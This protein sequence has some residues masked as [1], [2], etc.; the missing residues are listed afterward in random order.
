[1]SNVPLPL[2]CTLYQIFPL[3]LVILTIVG[4]VAVISAA[5]DE[6]DKASG[7]IP[8]RPHAVHPEVVGDLSQRLWSVPCTKSRWVPRYV[9]GKAKLPLTAGPVF[10]A[11]CPPRDFQ[12]DQ[13]FS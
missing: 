13:P 9:E 1:L 2:V 12:L 5:G 3:V 7:G 4:P 8:M 10:E 11:T 6:A